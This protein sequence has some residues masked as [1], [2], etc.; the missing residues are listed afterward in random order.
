VDDKR[1]RAANR[2]RL[3][4]LGDDKP[5]QRAMLQAFGESLRRLRTSAGFSQ[6]DLARHCLLQRDDISALERGVTVP[7][8]PVLLV[9][10]EALHAS[11]SE[12]TD[13]VPAPTRRATAAHVLALVNA[14]PGIYTDAIAKSLG[15]AAWYVRPVLRS[16]E[17]NQQVINRPRAGWHPTHSST[18]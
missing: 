5:E 17:L 10:R 15:L 12:L 3:L 1:E 16:L 8:L 2:R 4:A 14:L 9:L 11:T 7:V 13:G 18:G 6:D